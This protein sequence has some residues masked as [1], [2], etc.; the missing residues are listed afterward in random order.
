MSAI[1]KIAEAVARRLSNAALSYP[2]SIERRYSTAAELSDVET[3]LLTVVPMASEITPASRASDYFDCRIDIGIR[4]RIDPASDAEIDAMM[5]LTEEVIDA[6]R[7]EPLPDC[8]DAKFL[9]L[10]NDP[11]FSVDGVEE[12]HVFVSV[13]SAR[14]RVLR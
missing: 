2:V 13:V 12:R 10:T 6:L 11:A 5:R 9:S 3:P 4:R 14:Y 8:P 7:R 1:A